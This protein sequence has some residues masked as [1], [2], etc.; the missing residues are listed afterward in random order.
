MEVDKHYLVAGETL[1]YSTPVSSRIKALQLARTE[2]VAGSLPRRQIDSSVTQLLVL[3][4]GEAQ[5]HS[6]ECHRQPVRGFHWRRMIR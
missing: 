6:P 1:E 5:G 2:L 4:Y 3:L